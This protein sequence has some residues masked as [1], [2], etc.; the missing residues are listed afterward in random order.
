MARGIKSYMKISSGAK[1]QFFFFPLSKI[2]DQLV[3]V[4][5]CPVKLKEHASRL[6]APAWLSGQGLQLV[7]L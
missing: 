2:H 1:K 7:P 4:E 6:L 5:D 3:H